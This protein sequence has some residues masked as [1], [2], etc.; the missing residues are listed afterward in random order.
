MSW[1][2]RRSVHQVGSDLRSG[3]DIPTESRRSVYDSNRRVQY[4]DYAYLNRICVKVTR[5]DTDS[6]GYNQ[7]T[8]FYRYQNVF[9]LF[10]CVQCNPGFTGDGVT[11]GPDGDLDSVPDS[12]DNCPTVPNLSQAD[13][14]G[15]GLGD[16][17]DD[18][19]DGDGFTNTPMEVS[20]IQNIQLVAYGLSKPR[21]FK[22]ILIIVRKISTHVLFTDRS[23]EDLD[24]SD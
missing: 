17:C 20:V 21:S 19:I 12:T 14:D 6:S 9:Y 5:Q 1:A 15:D 24:S 16:S 8:F 11:C 18:D 10:L 3:S 7:M 22:F 4:S 2:L 23:P 13:L